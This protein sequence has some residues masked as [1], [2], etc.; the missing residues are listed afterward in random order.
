M[1]ERRRVR[2]GE[3]A[4]VL[5]GGALLAGSW[6]LVAANSTVPHWEARTFDAINGLPDP[7]WP[8]LWG[9]MQF[10]SMVG[11]LVVVGATGLVTR[12]IRLTLA[13]LVGSQVAFWMAKEV[14]AT[15]SRGRPKALL[16]DVH[17]REHAGGLGF[18]SGHA[19]VAFALA[20]ALAPSLPR[21]WRP[22]PFALAAT[23]AFARVYAGVHLPLDVVGGAGFGLLC[24]TVARWSFGLG[25]EGLPPSARVGQM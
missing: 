24:G 7:L 17:L 9:P 2:A 14:K 19:T 15:V 13:T 22:A 1:I 25:G 20:A 16:T 12:N 10:G 3:V 5:G 21:R 6:V 18:I 4:A 8:V 23:V 11:S